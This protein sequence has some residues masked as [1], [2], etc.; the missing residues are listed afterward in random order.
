MNQ[1]VS[2]YFWQHHSPTL[3]LVHFFILH[4]G[5]I[6]FNKTDKINWKNLKWKIK[7]VKIYYLESSSKYKNECLL[8]DGTVMDQT[9]RLGFGQIFFF[10]N[11]EKTAYSN[12]HLVKQVVKKCADRWW[13][14]SF[15]QSGRDIWWIVSYDL[16]K[17]KICK[18]LRW[19]VFSRFPKILR[20]ANIWEYTVLSE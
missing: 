20:N 2:I 5:W 13:G 16:F 15:I 7:H 4:F 8:Q 17:F 11:F 3:I 1:I 9:C 14:G 19:I 6:I 10:S 18:F 12:F